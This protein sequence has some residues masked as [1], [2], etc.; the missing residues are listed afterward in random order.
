M[1]AVFYEFRGAHQDGAFS[2][3]DQL[4]ARLQQL[5]AKAEE[6]VEPNAYG[7]LLQRCHTAICL[8]LP[9]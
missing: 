2:R 7:A 9:K 1:G 5:I 4:Y 6:L 8:V 3:A